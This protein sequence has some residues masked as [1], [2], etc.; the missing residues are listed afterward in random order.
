MSSAERKQDQ[1]QISFRNNNLHLSTES[2]FLI[3][4]LCPFLNP[5]CYEHV[6]KT[7]PIQSVDEDY[8]IWQK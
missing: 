8:E 2:I 1:G 6:M 5:K 4:F 3:L 7:G